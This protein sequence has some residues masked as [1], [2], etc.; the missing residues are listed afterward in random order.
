[1]RFF[2]DETIEEVE[3]KF[4]AGA[5]ESIFAAPTNICFLTQVAEGQYSIHEVVQTMTVQWIPHDEGAEDTWKGRL[6][7]LG[8]VHFKSQGEKKQQ[9]KS[10]SE[11]GTP[12]HLLKIRYK[13]YVEEFLKYLELYS[14]VKGQF[15]VA[16]LGAVMAFATIF[17][18]ENRLEDAK[19][20]LQTGKDR[21]AQGD[22]IQENLQA[23]LGL[24]ATYRASA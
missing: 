17:R 15:S 20:L 7:A 12:P 22:N 1:M 13:I 4:V 16:S 19:E 18:H 3:R 10:P 8:I 24:I 5:L 14:E 6:R 21:G 23:R 2:E 11:A 9:A